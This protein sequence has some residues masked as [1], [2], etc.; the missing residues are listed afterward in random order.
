[1]RL[2]CQTVAPAHPVPR[3]APEEFEGEKRNCRKTLQR[4]NE[5]RRRLREE[6]Q[7][8]KAE[9][10]G[11]AGPSTA[12]SAAA[13][14]SSEPQAEAEVPAALAASTRATRG[15]AAA[16]VLDMIAGDA[17][18]QTALNWAPAV[19]GVRVWGRGGHLSLAAA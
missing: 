16:M 11:E 13:A 2:R 5:R 4:H 19:P 10:S 7:G 8:Q 15:Q 3:P 1:M 12:T 9:Q 6:G 17:P 18:L 14:D